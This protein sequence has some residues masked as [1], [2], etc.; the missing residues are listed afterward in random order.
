MGPFGEVISVA[1]LLMN[2]VQ[3][4]LKRSHFQCK[5]KRLN[6]N[7][8]SPSCFPNL[9][10]LSSMQSRHPRQTDTWAP[11]LVPPAP[12]HFQL[13]P[14]TCQ[15]LFLLLPLIK[16]SY[17]LS[18]NIFENQPSCSPPQ[19]PFQVSSLLSEDLILSSIFLA[20]C[21]RRQYEDKKLFGNLY[22][23]CNSFFCCM[24]NPGEVRSHFWIVFSNF[25]LFW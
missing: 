25:F 5:H 1:L 18:K 20:Y 6:S 24:C 22:R 23:P 21:E 11:P 3:S 10:L 12:K 2:G 9:E 17:Q 16:P 7:V 4:N 14:L 8:K 15:W 13:Q 19:L